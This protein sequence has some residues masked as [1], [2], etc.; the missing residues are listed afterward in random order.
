ME[1]S[2]E[3]PKSG[4]FKP[5]LNHALIISAALIILTLALYLTGQLQN[6]YGG[7]ISFL[8]TLV[9]ILYAI[10]NYRNQN[11]GGFI[12]YGR[13]VQ[14]ALVVGFLVGIISGIFTFLLYGVISPELV[15]EARLHAEQ[16]IYRT[17]PNITYE[18]AEMALKIG[19]WF[20]TPVGL[21]IS[22]IFMNTLLGLIYGVIGGIFA[23]R[24]DP[25]NVEV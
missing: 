19:S 18:Q 20:T 22:S 7:W 15:E 21:L 25:M 9:G 10:F 3:P 23:K 1:N 17:N 16:E 6:K 4:L 11:L 13:V 2:Q 5:A 14:Y 8:V 12:S 24:N